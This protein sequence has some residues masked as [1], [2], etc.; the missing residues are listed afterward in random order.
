MNMANPN[1]WKPT[2]DDKKAILKGEKSFKDAIKGASDKCIP[3]DDFK[4]RH[5]VKRYLYLKE[6]AIKRG[7][8]NAQV[9]VIRKVLGFS[10]GTFRVVA[11]EIKKKQ[12]WAEL[13]TDEAIVKFMS[14]NPAMYGIKPVEVGPITAFSE[15]A[16]K[17]I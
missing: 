13:G 1:L 17:E 12:G 10:G 9:A 6:K 11:E 4:P 5:T 7:Y 16:G 2:Q 3:T 8:T 14:L 15:H